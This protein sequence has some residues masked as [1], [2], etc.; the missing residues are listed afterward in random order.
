MYD[1]TNRKEE[2]FA[3]AKQIIDKDVKVASNTIIAIKQEMRL[4]IE[5][6]ETA[7]EPASADHTLKSAGNEET[8]QGVTPKV[9]PNGAALPP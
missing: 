3:L 5:A 2:A 8:R 9:Q 1:D 4:L 7:E 6:Q